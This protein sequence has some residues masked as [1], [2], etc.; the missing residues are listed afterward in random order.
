V[1]T[2]NDKHL[3][4]FTLAARYAAEIRKWSGGISVLQHLMK[5]QEEVIWKFGTV[6]LRYTNLEFI[7]TFRIKEASRE[8]SSEENEGDI[9]RIEEAPREESSEG[10]EGDFLHRLVRRPSRQGEAALSTMGS[11]RAKQF[12]STSAAKESPHHV[13][14]CSRWKSALELV[15]LH[16]VMECVHG[17][18]SEEGSLFQELISDKWERFG[19]FH[20]LMWTLIPHF[21]VLGMYMILIMVRMTLILERRSGDSFPGECLVVLDQCCI[22]Y[23]RRKHVQNV[24]LCG[25]CFVFA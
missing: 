15:V 5:K 11:W 7:D 6:S 18:D 10:K 3:T 21:V 19:R 1:Q 4:P 9:H 2:L 12:E 17:D 16:E 8:E 22:A 20:H 25:Y 23:L 13:H 14:F 24:G